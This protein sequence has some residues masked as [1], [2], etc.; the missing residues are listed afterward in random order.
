[1]QA[2]K[3]KGHNAGLV[4]N[5]RLE[6]KR[7]GSKNYLPGCPKHCWCQQIPFQQMPTAKNVQ[8]SPRREAKAKR[9]NK[10]KQTAKKSKINARTLSCEYI[11]SSIRL[12]LCIPRAQLNFVLVLAKLLCSCIF[13]SWGGQL[14]E[15]AF[16]VVRAC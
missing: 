16:S 10:K 13:L 2:V 15:C 8:L 5:F 3:R 14:T 4:A 12:S 7:V 6:E 11:H 9:K 1:M